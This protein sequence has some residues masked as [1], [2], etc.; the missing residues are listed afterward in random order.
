[1]VARIHNTRITIPLDMLTISGSVLSIGYSSWLCFYDIAVD[2]CSFPWQ[3]GLLAATDAT[4]TADA[5]PHSLPVYCPAEYITYHKPVRTTATRA[6]DRE[7]HSWAG[8]QKQS[9]SKTKEVQA[10]SF[11]L[12][13]I[14]VL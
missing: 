3:L 9:R 6:G 11:K 14:V 7:P 1:M 5:T 10:H 2:M 12:L 4:A 13:L 8:W